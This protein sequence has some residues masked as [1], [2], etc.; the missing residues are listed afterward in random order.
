MEQKK[1]DWFCDRVHAVQEKMYRVAYYILE[2][3]EDSKDAVSE[4]ITLAY[5]KIHTLRNEKSFNTW[6]IKIVANKAKD[7]QKFRQRE[8]LSNMDMLVKERGRWDSYN[9][10]DDIMEI[11]PSQY[12]IVLK[13]YHWEDYNI[14]EISK[15]LEIPRG[16]V[17][18]RL[19]RG[20]KILRREFQGEHS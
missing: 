17:K 12:K 19:A 4:A 10:W 7:I 20:E 6:I 2:N 15:I 13:L 3:E 14:N 5:E 8:V 11:I 1:K 18:S 16:T 9:E